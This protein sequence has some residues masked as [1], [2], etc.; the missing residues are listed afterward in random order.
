[1][2]NII[3]GHPYFPLVA[4]S[5]IDTTVKVRDCP[6]NTGKLIYPLLSTLVVWTYVYTKFVFENG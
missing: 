4:V 2:V 5:G 1:M 3:E 6:L